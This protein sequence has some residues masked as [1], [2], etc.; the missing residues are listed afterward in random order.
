MRQIRQPHSQRTNHNVGH[1]YGFFHLHAGAQYG[2]YVP[3]HYYEG[4]ERPLPFV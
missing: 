4:L 3:Q 1:P 2:A